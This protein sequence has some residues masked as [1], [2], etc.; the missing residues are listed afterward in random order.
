MLKL[1][2]VA[3]QNIMRMPMAILPF[4]IIG[5]VQAGV[6]LERVNKFMNNSE[7]DPKAVE[8]D[9]EE[10][11]PVL[12]EGGTFKWGENEPEVLKD[13][14]IRVK[15]GSLTAVVGTVGAGT[16]QLI[17]SHQSTTINAF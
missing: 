17:L 12:V 14:N 11:D 15:K 5:L 7:L 10:V 3:F 1:S 8:H 9:P 4:L 2:L 16:E 6:S 13:I